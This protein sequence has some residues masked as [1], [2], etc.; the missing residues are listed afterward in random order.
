MPIKLHDIATGTK[1]DI[2]TKSPAGAQENL[3]FS[4][5]IEKTN[6]KTGEIRVLA[7]LE[8]LSGFRI[9]TGEYFRLYIQ[10]SGSLYQATCVAVGYERSNSAVILVAKMADNSEIENANRRNDY[11]VSTIL[12]VKIWRHQKS[13]N[14]KYLPLPPQLPDPLKCLSADISTGGIGVLTKE[15][16]TIG[17]PVK[18][19]LLLEKEDIKGTIV[20][21]GETVRSVERDKS[22]AYQFAAGIKITEISTGDASILMRFSLA[23]QREAL[24]MRNDKK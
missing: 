17:E 8:M 12:D 9:R 2:E 1:A 16:L 22:E 18:C 14:G 10:M 7:P 23:C 19:G 5:I 15:K 4:T 20:F 11:R 21:N 6:E 24:R 13:Q 3:L